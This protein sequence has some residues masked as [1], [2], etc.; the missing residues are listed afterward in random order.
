MHKKAML[1]QILFMRLYETNFNP[2]LNNQDTKELPKLFQI[3]AVFLKSFVINLKIA[4][5]LLF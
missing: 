3:V 4:T 2:F 5:A 1:L